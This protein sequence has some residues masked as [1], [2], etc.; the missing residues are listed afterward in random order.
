MH[1]ITLFISLS[2][3]SGRA[4]RIIDGDAVRIEAESGEVLNLKLIGVDGRDSGAAYDYLVNEVLGKTV[5][6]AF[7]AN[8]PSAEDFPW[9]YGYVY[10][11]R[12]FIN[13]RLLQ[14]GYAKLDDSYNRA[15]YYKLLA[16]CAG[17]AKKRRLGVFD[18]FY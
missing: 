5:A 7:D 3:I 12:I 9:S 15:V 13:A 8:Y 2:L 6:V 17:F 14:K 4:S 11:N 1:F 18:D 16:E 10:S